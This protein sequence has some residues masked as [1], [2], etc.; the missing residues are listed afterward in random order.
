MVLQFAVLQESF[1]LRIAC[2]CYVV[3]L[4]GRAR[5][6]WFCPG[7]PIT[8]VILISVLLYWNFFMCRFS[9][10]HIRYAFQCAWN[11]IQREMREEKK[12]Q[13]KEMMKATEVMALHGY[14]CLAACESWLVIVEDCC[15]FYHFLFRIRLAYKCAT[16]Q[17]KT[18]I[19]DNRV[20]NAC[21]CVSVCERFSNNLN[22]FIYEKLKNS[23]IVIPLWLCSHFAVCL[24]CICEPFN[25]ISSQK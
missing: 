7:K 17:S 4:R 24:H 22:V 1:L 12:T 3:C 10:Q 11:R 6:F 25:I 15:F 8:K 18:D 14:L 9:S 2:E 16:I 19:K 13:K 21:M 20:S 5:L 23:R